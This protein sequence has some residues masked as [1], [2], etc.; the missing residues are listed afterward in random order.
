MDKWFDIPVR[1]RTGLL[2]KHMSQGHS[3]SH[4]RRELEGSLAKYQEGGEVSSF[5]DWDKIKAVLNPKNWGVEDYTDK[6]EFG[7]AYSS[8][9]QAGEKEFMW[10][11]KRYSTTMK[12][13]PGER[14]MERDDFKGTIFTRPE[15]KEKFKNFKQYHVNSK[16]GD[17]FNYY[18]GEPLIAGTHNLQVSKYRPDD[19]TNP[20]SKYISIQNDEFKDAIVYYLNNYYQETG[21]SN[22]A[23]YIRTPDGKYDLN[24]RPFNDLGNFKIKKLSDS[25]GE[26]VQY[27][28]IWDRSRN[29]NPDLNSTDNLGLTKPFEV[30]DRI[31]VKDYGD[32][33]QRRMYYSDKELS[34]L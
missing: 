19:E 12:N 25:R 13:L 32:G 29:N 10:N 2:R 4:S 7:E 18:K 22:R 16:H 31:Y 5:P 34:E 27:Y 9:R 33:I 23:S 15:S 1:I 24:L 8:A 6:G 20:N 11:G 30:Y 21:K 14:I 3:Y 17:L 28:D 26:Y